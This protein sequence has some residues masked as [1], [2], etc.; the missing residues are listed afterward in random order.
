MN[1]YATLDQIKEN[2]S[3]AA[4]TTTWDAQLLR[5]LEAASREVDSYCGRHFYVLTDTKYF[6]IPLERFNNTRQR[7]E[8]SLQPI[9]R[10]DTRT[11]WVPDI[12]S[13]TTIKMD[14]NQD[15]T[16]EDTLAATDYILWPFESS[17]FPKRGV[18][19]DERQG[20]YA[21]FSSGQRVIE[22]A[23]LWGYGTGRSATPYND[24]GTDVNEVFNS[25]DTTLTVDAGTQFEVGQ[26]ILIESEQLWISAISTHNLT[27]ERG[28]N[29]TTAASHAN[30]SDIY[31]YEYPYPVQE[32]VLRMT[33]LAYSRVGKGMAAER[34]GD[35]SYT[36][37]SVKEE[38]ETIWDSLVP[39][40]IPVL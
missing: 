24:A 29:G 12:L 33:E 23:A 9:I 15:A 28:V 10:D 25:T 27:V 14:S 8:F 19:M 32:A 21:T 5:R 3:I 7:Q 17:R 26:T 38:Y 1:L 13:V 39:Y 4:A 2:L 31:I 36:K 16:Y 22:I 35:Y 34:L 30:N 6:D 18:Q 40:G 37:G 11:L 20:D